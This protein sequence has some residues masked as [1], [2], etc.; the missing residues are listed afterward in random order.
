MVKTTRRKAKIRAKPG[1][2][3]K[4]R[5]DWVITLDGGLRIN[6]GYYPNAK[7]AIAAVSRE[8][9]GRIQSVRLYSIPPTKATQL[10]DGKGVGGET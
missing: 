9:K 7:M 3:I 8:H 4:A 10:K 2:K 5:D 1:P 6:A